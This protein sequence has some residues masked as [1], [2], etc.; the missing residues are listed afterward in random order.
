MV[1]EVVKE[2]EF[3][4]L[5]KYGLKIALLSATNIKDFMSFIS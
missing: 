5:E 2:V 3:V 4:T 1:E